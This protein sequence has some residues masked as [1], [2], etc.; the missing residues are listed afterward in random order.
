MQKK[1]ALSVPAVVFFSAGI[2][3]YYLYTTS[4]ESR[5]NVF[6]N[7]NIKIITDNILFTGIFKLKANDGDGFFLINGSFIRQNG[8]KGVINRKVTFKYTRTEEMWTMNSDKTFTLPSDN[9]SAD[10][11]KKLLPPFY[12][13]SGVTHNVGIYNQGSGY[14]FS[15]GA[16]PFA[17]CHKN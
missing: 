4:S 13:T 7:S 9:A 2:L 5:E 11:L 1:L 17:Y 8:S 14:I 16:I 3:T 6:C 15:G 12:F 10:E